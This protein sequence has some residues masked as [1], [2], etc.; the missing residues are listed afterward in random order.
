MLSTRPIT[1]S[2]LRHGFTCVVCA[3]SA[4]ASAQSAVPRPTVTRSVDLIQEFASRVPLGTEAVFK[5]RP[6][7]RAKSIVDSG[8]QV[9]IFGLLDN[10]T[11]PSRVSTIGDCDIYLSVVHRLEKTPSGELRFGRLDQGWV[12]VSYSGNSPKDGRWLM[13][14]EQHGPTEEQF[15]I[16]TTDAK[17]YFKTGFVVIVFDTGSVPLSQIKAEYERREGEG[18]RLLRQVDQKDPSVPCYR[19][20]PVRVAGH[21]EDTLVASNDGCSRPVESTSPA[22]GGEPA[23]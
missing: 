5:P 21:D 13:V 17:P 1:Q 2:L 23:G 18:A 4:T 7:A 22:D 19:Y 10:E 14:F 16:R 20:S 11:K 3:F 6:T 15:R 9:R 8:V 12:N